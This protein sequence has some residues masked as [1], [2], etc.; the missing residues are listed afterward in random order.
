MEVYEHVDKLA[1]EINDLLV[2]SLNDKTDLT[3]KKIARKINAFNK[4]YEYRSNIM[5]RLTNK[6]QQA[7]EKNMNLQQIKRWNDNSIEEFYDGIIK[8]LPRNSLRQYKALQKE[9]NLLLASGQYTQEQAIKTVS[10]NFKGVTVKDSLNR[11]I[12]VETVVK[13]HIRDSQR[14]QANGLSEHIAKKYNTDV[15]MISNHPKP[16]PKCAKDE[17]KYVSDTIQG[18][19]EL[20]T[21]TVYVVSWQDTSLGDP[22][23]LFGYN[24]RHTKWAVTDFFNPDKS[25]IQVIEKLPLT[26]TY[27]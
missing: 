14:E 18:E 23:G 2:E 22:D 16:R 20:I 9:V 24:C 1:L 3:S 7:Y 12:R 8:Q 5:N 4:K 25:N 21:E 11:N 15:Y 19:L 6:I 26:K 17:R 27:N 10:T 13:R